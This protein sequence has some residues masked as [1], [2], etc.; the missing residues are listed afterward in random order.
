[1]WTVEEIREKYRTFEDSKIRELANNPRGLR[2]E[3]VPILKEEIKR[4]NLDVAI[5]EWIDNEINSFE[6]LE[7]QNLVRKIAKSKCSLCRTDSNLDGYRFN[8]IISFL[9]IVKNKTEIR[10]ICNNCAGSKRLTSMTTTFFLGWWSKK[11]IPLTPFTVVSDLIKIFRKEFESKKVIDQFIDGNTGTLRA[12]L[13]KEN[14]LD[15]VLAQFN[16]L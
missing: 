7:R 13:K 8:T 15:E 5:T 9:F 12:C 16:K 6:G 10:I 14:G 4:R 3:I 11:G 1:M 2:K